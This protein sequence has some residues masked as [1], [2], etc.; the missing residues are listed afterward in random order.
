MSAPGGGLSAGGG[1]A[2]AGAGGSFVVD[3]ESGGERS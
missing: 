3:G 2:P 1:Y